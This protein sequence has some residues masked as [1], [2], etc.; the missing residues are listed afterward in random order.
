MERANQAMA[1]GGPLAGPRIGRRLRSVAACHMCELG[2][3]PES[4]SFIPRTRVEQGRDL[5]PL[6]AFLLESRP[7]WI[8]TVCGRCSGNGSPVR[9]RPHLLE[10]LREDPQLALDA[11]HSLINTVHQ[12][13]QRYSASFRWEL[14]GSDTAEDRSG[15]V[16]AA[17]WCG[18]WKL[19]LECAGE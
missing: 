2:Y 5:S 17:G 7:H 4:K 13:V 1:L 11:H 10:D 18:G 3:G 9:C 8:A 16:S 6:R 12:R 14:Q 19:L 15:L